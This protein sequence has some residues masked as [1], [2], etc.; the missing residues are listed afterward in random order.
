VI[1][2]PSMDDQ[3][4]RPLFPAD[5]KNLKPYRRIVGDPGRKELQAMPHNRRAPD[6]LANPF[7]ATPVLCGTR[8]L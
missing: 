8:L 6:R 4:A 1:I 3:A 7:N 5:W 2:A